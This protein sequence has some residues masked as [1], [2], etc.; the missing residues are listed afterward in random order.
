M[1]QR[2]YA[3]YAWY[4]LLRTDYKIIFDIFSEI[5]Q[6][7]DFRA[8]K[9]QNVMMNTPANLKNIWHHIFM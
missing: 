3:G 2:W 5:G 9:A 4:F 8:L 7:L 6:P 1:Y